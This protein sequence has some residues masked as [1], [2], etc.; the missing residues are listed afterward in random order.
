VTQADRIANV[1]HPLALGSFRIW[2]KLLKDSDGIDRE[3]WLRV[4]FVSLS[5]LFTSPL[6]LYE[7]ARYDR[8]VKSTAIHPSPIFIIGHWRSGTTHLHNLMCQDGNLG[9]ISTFQ[10]MA[11][12]FCLVGQ[13]AIKPLLARIARKVHPTRLI[14]NIPLSFD[15]PQEEEFAVAN[16]SPY[17]FFH[18]FTFPCQ[19]PYF[20]E[21][22]ALFDGLSG[23]VL[24]DWKETYLTVLRKATLSTGGKRLVLKNPAHSGRIRTLLGLFPDA[25]FIHIYRNPYRVFLSTLWAYEVVL[26]RSQV[27][28]VGP[29]QIEAYVLRFYRQL[30][31]RFLADRALIPTGNLVEVKFEDLEAA[32]LEQL[33]R[34]YESLDLPGFAEAEP[35]FHAYLPSIRDYQKNEYELSDKVIADVNRHWQF[36]FDAWG[37]PHLRPDHIRRTGQQ[38]RRPAQPSESITSQHCQQP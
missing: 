33:R 36:A 11:P 38:K 16:M 31:Q 8:A 12:G 28:K 27:Q 22:Y 3:F 13:R 10:A 6:R 32:P 26:S 9:Y 35:A 37:Y 17:S 1:E 25:K 21:R 15:A 20:I 18:L 19:A 23:Q 7:H 5:T 2:F 14:D 34:V 24:D 30:M 29:D 4:L